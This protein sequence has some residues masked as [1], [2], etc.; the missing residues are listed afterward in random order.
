MNK[1]QESND[2]ETKNKSLEN[3]KWEMWERR[4]GR[5]L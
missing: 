1:I 3:V 4:K 5:E 2:N